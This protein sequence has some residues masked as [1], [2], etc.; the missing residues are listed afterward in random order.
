MVNLI[1]TIRVLPTEEMFFLKRISLENTPYS[2][3]V[4]Y[5]RKVSYDYKI[6]PNEDPHGNHLHMGYKE[7]EYPCDI[8]DKAILNHIQEKFTKAAPYT[9]LMMFN[10]DKEQYAQWLGQYKKE[11]LNVFIEY[12]PTSSSVIGV[13]PYY[14]EIE[15]LSFPTMRG[16]HRKL[17]TN[18]YI[19]T[20]KLEEFK[21]L[22]SLLNGTYDLFSNVCQNA[23]I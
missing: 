15:V 4:C 12:S 11:K 17:N 8:L 18:I 6:T 23:K 13:D 2:D 3:I 10:S 7:S 20:D 19:N 9:S 21:R 14:K 1:K 22:C 16:M 5:A